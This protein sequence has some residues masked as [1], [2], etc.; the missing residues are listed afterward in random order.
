MAT[1]Y[2]QALNNSPIHKDK[3]TVAVSVHAHG[4][5]VARANLRINGQAL[6][7][8][9]S[10]VGYLSVPYPLGGN[11]FVYTLDTEVYF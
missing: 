9:R 4:V 10:P 2:R 1:R 3:V 6:Y 8:S 7:L 5:V 11:G